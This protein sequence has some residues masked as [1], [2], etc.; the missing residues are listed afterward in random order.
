[1]SE[2]AFA[3]GL[4]IPDNSAYTAMT[5]LRRLGIDVDRVERS[6]IVRFEDGGDPAELRA[7]IE[8]D[9]FVFNPNKH[10]LTLLSSA[11]PR[12]GEVWIETMGGATTVARLAARRYVGW[13][14]FTHD[15]TP[16]PEATVKAAV[17]ALLCNP[18]IEK[19]I[20]S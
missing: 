1:M 4:K 9:E 8:R 6:E 17:E 12:A 14:L 2:R 7:H 3:I 19:A 15:G 20:Y 5:T 16:A 18:A 10:R 11:K 13:R